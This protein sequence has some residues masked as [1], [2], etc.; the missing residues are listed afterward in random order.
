MSVYVELEERTLMEA[1]D[2][3]IQV[4]FCHHFLRLLLAS[5]CV[6]FVLERTFQTIPPIKKPI[7]NRYNFVLLILTTNFRVDAIHTK[8]DF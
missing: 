5:I 4:N 1:L 8:C 7:S 6:S 3:L 2:K